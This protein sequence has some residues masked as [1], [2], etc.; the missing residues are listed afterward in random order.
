LNT[1]LFRFVARALPALALALS[2]VVAH[3]SFTARELAQGYSDITLLAKPRAELASSVESSELAEGMTIRERFPRM[4]NLRVLQARTGE[5]ASEAI[6]RLRGT[7]RYEYVEPD[8]IVHA[9]VTP[10]DPSFSQQWSLT[11][12]GAPSAWDFPSSPNAL[13]VIVA[14]VDSGIYLTHED[15]Q[16]NLWPSKGI[17]AVSG[18]GTIT[19]TDPNDA[20]VGHGTHVA[21]II[22]AVGNNGKGISGVVWQTQL[23][24]LRF[25]HGAD[26]QGTTSDA[27]RC[28]NY[29][30]S[31]GASIINASY[32]SDTYSQAEYDAMN[33]AR[34]AGIIVVAAAGNDSLNTDS[35]NDF[36]AG[37]AL[38]N[39]VSV[40]ATDQNDALAGFSNYG[41]GSVDL[42]APGVNILSTW[43]TNSSSYANASGTS[44]AAPHVSGA[45]ALLKMQFP[46][47]TY[48]QLINRLLRAVT[49]VSGLSGKVQSGGRLNIATAVS[50]TSNLPF[51]DSFAS[52]AVLSGPN[53]RVRSNNVGATRELGEPSHGGITANASLWWSWTASDNSQVAFET[54]DSNYD[55]VLEV[56]TGTSLTGL[57][58]IA[59]NDNATGVTTSRLTINATAG[60]TYQIAV[61]GKNANTGF[62]VL[63]IG[64][65]PPNDNFTSAIAL[66][67][68]SVSVSATLLNASRESGEPNVGNTEAP[69]TV[70]YKWTA[71]SSGHYALSVFAHQV[72]S[73]AGVY[74]G[75]SVSS[76]TAVATNNDSSSTNTDALVPFDATGGTT[77][78]FQV[79]HS[80]GDGTLG[81]DFTL[82]LTP[83]VWEFPANDEVTSSPAVGSDGTIYFGAGSSDQLD[84]RIYA[85]SSS[86]TK[87][88]TVSTGA[89]GIVGASPAIAPDGTVYVGSDNKILYALNGS[90][91]AT[92]W[93]FTA[94][95]SLSSTPA[96]GSDGTI[97]FRDDTTLYALSSSG[98]QKWAF[99]LGSSAATYSSPV[100][101]ADG[102]IYVGIKGAL[103]AVTDKTSSA[104][105]KWTF[106]TA[107]DIYSTPAIGSDGTIYFGTVAASGTSS[108]GVF[109]ALTPGSSSATTK[110]SVSL[111]A[112]TSTIDGQ[113]NGLSSSPALAA[114]GTVYFAAYDHTLYAYT[115]NGSQ[116]WTYTL[117]DEVR[118]S[119]S[120][121]GADGTVYIGCYD[122]KMYAVSSSGALLHAYATAKQIRSSPTISGTRLYFGSAD[123]KL[124][125]I[126]VGQ[127][128]AASP[129]PMFHADTSHTG[130]A[131]TP[132][133]VNIVTPPQSRTVLVGSSVT[134]SVSATGSG[135]LTYQ[136]YKN[137]TAISG[138]TS[139]SLTLNNV[140][141]SDSGNYTVTVTSGS[142]TVTSSAAVVS[143]VNVG[144]GS[145]TFADI[146]TRAYC[147][148]GNNVT[149]GGFVVQG[150]TTKRVLIRAVGPSL[151]AQ[152]LNAN[153]L[154][155]DPTVDVYKGQT[156]IASNDN[157]GTGAN[158][159]ASEITSLASQLGATPLSSSDTKSAAL[160]LTLNPGV[161]TF[162]VHGNNSTSGIVLLEVYDADVGIGSKFVNI[163]TR[164]YSTTG[165]GV[166]IGG[167]V[168]SGSGAK[169][170]LIRAVGPTLISQGIA[171][172]EVLADPVIELHDAIH[173]NITIGTND[174]W[175]DNSNAS[176]ITATGARLGATPISSSD[177]KSSALLLT[178]N[179]GVYTFIASGKANTSGIVLV[180]VYDAD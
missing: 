58:S 56:Y 166:A 19:D 45:L 110:W 84:N 101:G 51:N 13:G 126:D 146:A 4:G 73:I 55:T 96:I 109:Y 64:V 140:S 23:M 152:G 31:N 132:S 120:A 52:R 53:V 67:G 118:A 68:E 153:D 179:P 26:G 105:A 90:T 27:I 103:Y 39:I 150:S 72:D 94:G 82:T 117:G 70:W 65:V 46:T 162:V 7:G 165:G 87:K 171:A 91:G 170:V 85:V 136:W 81:G 148:T 28:I 145:A 75:S 16:A 49:K 180:E 123:A 32:G 78:Y 133:S 77:Y 167:F 89:A 160:I 169:Q 60:T 48:R 122:A 154:L 108:S 30:I 121:V 119:S 22:G 95:T 6:A 71:P 80:S 29:A 139:A 100:I 40:A 161:Y 134:L 157:W 174:N 35:G 135:T 113:A 57:N 107:G 44:M 36:P 116:K 151:A 33:S 34:T 127:S 130:V 47:D 88:W 12:I 129:W 158:S 21:G 76:L 156:V 83:A 106:T 131:V 138:A 93:T 163:A 74:T 114:D 97:Y 11:K 18:N 38:D 172:N 124:Y 63:H 10:N 24:A 54:T 175:T 112:Y 104:T 98:A 66:T 14:I 41:A 69:Q 3:A 92:K 176:D 8:R 9:R 168:I 125:A 111:P 79:S 102:T 137:G 50:S 86:G 177:T 115:S 1:L 25:L 2:A 173:G 5:R 20:E 141:T 142:T 59:S 42:G 143:V 37:L 15:L 17:S 155:A 99:P 164:A 178:L 159:T 147:G 43:N 144:S 128:A 62:T 149:I 61:D